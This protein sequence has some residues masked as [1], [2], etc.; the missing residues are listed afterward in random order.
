MN[1]PN[2]VKGLVTSVIVDEETGDVLMVAWMNEESYEKTIM[3]GET[4]FWSRSRQELWHKGETSGNTQIVKSIL[5]DCDQ[6]TL[7]IRVKP[8]GPACHTGKRTC[9]FE[10]IK[11]KGEN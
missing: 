9:F 4:W 3:T 10:E 7:L 5:L 6:D 2:F 1:R 11:F 8:A